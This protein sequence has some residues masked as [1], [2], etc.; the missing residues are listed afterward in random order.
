MKHL[1]SKTVFSRVDS[2]L[3]GKEHWIRSQDFSSRASSFIGPLSDLG[4]S[5]TL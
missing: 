3:E 5:S 2:V 4:I 1:G